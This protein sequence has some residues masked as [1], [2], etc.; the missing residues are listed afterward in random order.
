MGKSKSIQQQQKDNQDFQKYI[1]S[2][3]SNMEKN[4]ATT[5]ALLDEMANEHYKKFDDKTTLMQGRYSHLSTT[6]EWSLNSINNI[7]KLCKN[8]LFGDSLPTGSEG[9]EKVNPDVS[10]SIMALKSRELYIANAACNIIQAVMGGFTN[11]TSTSIQTK[12]DAKP[13]S[14]GLMLF[15]GVMYNTYDYKDIFRKEKIMQSMIT[16]KVHYSIKEGLMQS[17]LSDLEVYEDQKVAMRAKLGEISKQ[18]LALDFSK[19]GFKEDLALL[20]SFAVAIREMMDETT[21]EIEKLTK[22]SN[23]VTLEPD[24]TMCEV[25]EIVNTIENRW[26]AV[27]KVLIFN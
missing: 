1:E 16:F 12:Y 11:S 7:I 9:P 6:S 27:K 23:V 2:M 14:P 17:K 8:A 18:I 13:L 25:E 4:I 3:N 22:D 10:A 5:N 15:I 20:N 24:D 26:N 19:D 21:K